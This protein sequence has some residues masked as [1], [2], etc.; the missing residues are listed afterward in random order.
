MKITLKG[1]R[2]FLYSIDKRKG[3]ENELQCTIDLNIKSTS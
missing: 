3:V 2:I 1:I